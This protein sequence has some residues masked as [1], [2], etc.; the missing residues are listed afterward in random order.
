MNCKFCALKDYDPTEEWEFLAHAKTEFTLK[1]SVT[2]SI[3]GQEPFEHFYDDEM[4]I[5]SCLGLY[6]DENGGYLILS[7]DNIDAE[8][9]LDKELITEKI[10]INYCPVCGRKLGGYDHGIL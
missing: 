3:D 8:N 10:R 1:K 9:I 7:T 2:V 4:V 5:D 6:E